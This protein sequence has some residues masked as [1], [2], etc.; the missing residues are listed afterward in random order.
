MIF[1]FETTLLCCFSSRVRSW[2]KMIS[3]I[4]ETEKLSTS[5][6]HSDYACFSG[7]KDLLPDPY[8][9]NKQD[10]IWSTKEEPHFLRR[11]E[12]LKKYP[13]VCILVFQL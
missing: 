3:K 10:F 12:I 8:R 6:K 13:Q 9:P 5:A 1:W 7:K 11:K 2:S 4:L